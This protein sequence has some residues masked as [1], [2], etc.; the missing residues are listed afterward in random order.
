MSPEEYFGKECV[1]SIRNLLAE[2]KKATQED[3]VMLANS[4]RMEA[5]KHQK[6]FASIVL[7]KLAERIELMGGI[8]NG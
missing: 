2:A 8:C 6:Q 7:V 1:E 5:E 4:L 3:R